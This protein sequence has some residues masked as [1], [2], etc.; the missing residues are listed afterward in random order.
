ME[1]KCSS[2]TFNE[3]VVLFVLRGIKGGSGTPLASLSVII[4]SRIETIFFDEQ[5]GE[6]LESAGLSCHAGELNPPL[7]LIERQGEEG[8]W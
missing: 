7:R 3:L 5:D 4:S 2:F 6:E 1:E 8:G